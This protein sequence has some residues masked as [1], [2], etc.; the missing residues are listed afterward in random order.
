GVA[1][2]RWGQAVAAVVARRPGAAVGADELR[3]HVGEQLAG[4]KKP[5][6]LV[7]IDS[8]ERTPSGKADMRRLKSLV[9]ASLS[10]G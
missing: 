9:E 2:R 7:I 10:A 1:D 8:L 4:Y 3:A 5:R 6:H